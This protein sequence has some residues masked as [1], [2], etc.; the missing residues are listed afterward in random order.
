[1]VPNKSDINLF[2]QT[3]DSEERKRGVRSF[4][5]REGRMTDAQHRA[6]DILWPEYG[7]DQMDDIKA[8]S[9]FSKVSLDIGF[10]N[11]ESVIHAAT[12]EPDV[13]HIGIEVHRP[14][15]GNLL[16]K[17]DEHKLSNVRVIHADAAQLI[18]LVPDNFI[19]RALI[20]FPDP[21]PKKRHHKRRLIQQEFIS[22][23]YPK[24]VKSGFIHMATDWQPYAAHMLEQMT[25]TQ[26]NTTCQLQNIAKKPSN[27]A[28]CA[29][30]EQPNIYPFVKR[31]DYRPQTKYE[32]R[33]VK[34]GHEV[35]DIMFQKTCI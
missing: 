20:F 18:R 17:I 3:L 22:T 26:E 8:L 29:N 32:R 35:F 14:G 11:G 12:V 6:F 16:Q 4:V 28:L 30:T 25:A 27:E 34:L 21:W 5:I 10:G 2:S 24:I 7:V 13:L 19:H 33:G 31:P 23:L 15:I 9:Q 1:M